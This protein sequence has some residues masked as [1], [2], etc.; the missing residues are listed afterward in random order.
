MLLQVAIPGGAVR[1]AEPMGRLPRP[2]KPERR[3]HAAP[4]VLAEVIFDPGGG[5]RGGDHAFG[6][7]RRFITHG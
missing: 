3:P 6:Q 1:Q 4:S 5:T 7:S 2:R